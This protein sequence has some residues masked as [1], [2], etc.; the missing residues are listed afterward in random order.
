[1]IHIMIFSDESAFIR[2]RLFTT[3]PARTFTG[4]GVRAVEAQGWKVDFHM[5]LEIVVS[6]E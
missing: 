2:V 4:P 1:M 5:V 3:A 6:C